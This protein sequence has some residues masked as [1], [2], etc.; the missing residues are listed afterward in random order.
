MGYDYRMAFIYHRVPEHMDGNILY[1]L[2]ELKERN[3]DLYLA[4]QKHHEFQPRVLEGSI[5][6]LGCF[7]DDVLHFTALSPTQIMATLQKLGY[8]IKPKYYEIDAGKLS[9]DKTIVFTN[10]PR[11]EGAPIK[12]TD[13]IPF[14]PGEVGKLAYI[15]E[16][17]SAQERKHIPTADEFLLNYRAPYILYKGSLSVEGTK[18]IEV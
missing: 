8:T 5:P 18:I 11:E 17:A 15:P 10:R 4:H 3:P 9:L 2:N 1:P 13:F 12:V 6:K 7:W 14:I 16:E